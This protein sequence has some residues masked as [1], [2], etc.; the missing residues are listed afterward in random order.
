MARV[1]IDLPEKY[2][3]ETEIKVRIGDVNYG[4]HV[5]NDAILSIAHD[6]RIDFFN[7]LGYS[8]LNIE[9][10]GIIM[11]DSAIIY[12][13]ESF[14]GDTLA[15]KIGINDISRVGF[16]LVYHFTKK[17]DNTDIAIVKT[18][19]ICFDYD[20]RKVVAIPEKAK[21]KLQA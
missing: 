19:M 15:I 21:I 11:S 7:S 9:G 6:A 12:K 20:K 16:D 1:K 17:E 10:S 5:G 4:G 13:G 14:Y 8:E 18:G 3:F 2:L